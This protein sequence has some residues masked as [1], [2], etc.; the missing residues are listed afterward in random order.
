MHHYYCC[1][2]YK[3]LGKLWLILAFKFLAVSAIHAP[4]LQ[5]K[6]NISENDNNKLI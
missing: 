4:P 1:Q 3:A 6:L 5:T 2:L